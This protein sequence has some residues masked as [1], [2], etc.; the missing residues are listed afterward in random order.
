MGNVQE[1]TQ[2]APRTT[3]VTPSVAV[4]LA[5]SLWVAVSVLSCSRPIP[6]TAR[7]EFEAERIEQACDKV[8]PGA[9]YA[10]RPTNVLLKERAVGENRSA[11]ERRLRDGRIERR[12]RLGRKQIVIRLAADCAA[13]LAG[14]EQDNWRP[15]AGV[16]RHGTHRQKQRGE[17]G[18]RVRAKWVCSAAHES[19]LRRPR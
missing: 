18:Y 10:V 19:I 4:P 8:E 1:V 17:S 15:A 12:R 16:R 7:N 2:R 9:H 11:V 5:S 6:D 3:G 14:A 13:R